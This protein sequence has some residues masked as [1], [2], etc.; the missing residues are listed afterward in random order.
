[1]ASPHSSPKER[2]SEELKQKTLF[3]IPKFKTIEFFLLKD[4]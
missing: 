4:M 3:V 1:M 2:R